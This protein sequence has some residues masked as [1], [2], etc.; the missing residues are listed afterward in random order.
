MGY[1]PDLRQSVVDSFNPLISGADRATRGIRPLPAH[2]LD[3]F[4]PLIS[5]ADRATERKVAPVKE[6]DKAFQS[7]HKRGG[8]RDM[9]SRNLTYQFFGLVS[10]PS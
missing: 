2:L 8:S 10:I 7:P 9:K 6:A 4:N 3:G 5:G 1:K